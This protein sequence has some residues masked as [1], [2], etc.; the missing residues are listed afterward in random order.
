MKRLS[1]ISDPALLKISRKAL[2]KDV[3]AERKCGILSNS[4]SDKLVLELARDWE[5]TNFLLDWYCRYA[6][7]PRPIPFT[8]SWNI[9]TK[10]ALDT[11][12]SFQK[13]LRP[14]NA[15][16][17]WRQSNREF[18][19]GMLY[20]IL[21]LLD[22]WV[23]LLTGG[24]LVGLTASLRNSSR[25]AIG[26]GLAYYLVGAVLIDTKTQ[27]LHDLIGRQTPI[28]VKT[29]NDVR[30]SQKREINFKR[31]VYWTTLFKFLM[32]HMWSLT[33]ST[34]LIWTFQA[35]VE[36]MI[37]F[38]AYVLAY[39]G[40]LWYQ[41]TKIFSGPH[42]LKPLLLGIAVG[43]PL[44][45]SLKLCLP[46]FQYPQVIGLGAS[47][48][49]VAI[50]SLWTAKIGMPKK[51]GSLMERGRK[52]HA[53]TTPWDDPEW[54]QQELQGLYEN[55]SR[56]SS[57]SRLFLT[58]K[59]HPGIEV[60]SLLLSQKGDPRVEEAFPKFDEIIA[61]AVHA[62]ERGN[63]TVE[64]VSP[65]SLGPGIR[66]LSCSTESQLTIIVGVG[67]YLGK[68]VDIHANCQI[69]AET[70]LHAVTETMFKMSHKNGVLAESLAT[71][72][73]TETM[74]Q[75]LREESRTPV[76]VHW[77]RRELLQQLCLG[78]D[79]DFHWEKLPNDIRILLLDRCTGQPCLLSVAQREWLQERLCQ[80]AA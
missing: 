58:P 75:Q 59:T 7:I 70:L 34:A 56:V 25:M 29:V 46:G 32:W 49:I 23:E 17:H 30:I 18:G 64:L 24:H 65:G 42:A 72:G 15:F 61:T 6:D 78:L 55:L 74:A 44:G 14:H 12:R 53:Y 76:A 3:L 71:A 16:I 2:L 8:S 37:M 13:G 33:F 54:S 9:Q 40:L 69:I 63:M 50:L 39:T 31:K 52:F 5:S 20:F 26:F 35:S 10:V 79:C 60:K 1:K 21:A 80:S 4:T 67:R 77:T 62:W 47:T 41:Y 19:C 51:Q 43:L 73:I 57:G 66:A 22:K 11:L 38:L 27:E 36:A 68:Q 45:I 48:W 28:E